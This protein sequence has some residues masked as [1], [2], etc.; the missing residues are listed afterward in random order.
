LKRLHIFYILILTF[1]P[2]QLLSQDE[3]SESI[4]FIEDLIEQI[5][6]ESDQELDYQTLLYDLSGY[7]EEPLNVNHASREELE[8]LH[9]LTDFQ[10]I[11][12]LQHIRDGG[13]LLTIYEL[14][15]VYGFDESL[16]R[17]L[18][19]LL[20][21]ESSA[22]SRELGEKTRPSHQLFLRF[23]SVIEEQKGFS[24][25][26]DSLLQANPNARYNGNRMKA[27]SKYRFRFGSRIEA[28][29]TGEKDAGEPFLQNENRHGF[30]FNSAYL[31]INDIG[32]FNTI[33]AGDYQARAGQ[34]V[35]LG[36]GL[37]F[38][39]SPDIINIRKKG[40]VLKPYSSSNENMFMRGLAASLEHKWLSMTGFISHKKIDANTYVDTIDNE[41]YFSSFLTSGLH[42]V[43]REFEDKDAVRETMLGGSATFHFGNLKT[44]ATVV[45]YFYDASYLKNDPVNMFHFSGMSNTNLG[46]DY[47]Y[48]GKKFIVFGEGGYSSNGTFAGLN[49]ASFDLHSQVTV[50]VL[51]RYFDRAFHALYGNA[52]TENSYNRN[53]H[54]L[55]TG[56]EI[57]PFPNWKISGYMDAYSFPYLKKLVT[58]PSTSGYDYHVQAEFSRRD[59]IHAYIRYKNKF[60][61]ENVS[62][63]QAGIPT[64]DRA[65]TSHL[66]FHISYPVAPGLTFADRV[67]ISAFE[68]ES[69]TQEGGFLAYHDVLYRP[70]S[71]PFSLTFRYSMFDT[72]S[73]K[74]RI[75]TYEHDV[76]YSF[77]IPNY[78]G[79][80]IRTYLTGRW[81][82]NR[83]VDLWLKYAMT[84]YPDRETI[85][86][87]LNEIEGHHRQDVRVQMRLKF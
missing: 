62:G 39:K 64:L 44:G 7:L 56:I 33:I 35:V 23:S 79:R 32:K 18:E 74:S 69:G 12:L 19:P 24:P 5:A 1:I 30:D 49:G 22:L 14:P 87:G 26:T 41:D 68:K 50:S 67:E 53:E 85:S 29:Y 65:R 25:A 63:D 45:H 16:A 76:L 10:I 11:S 3:A 37:S 15:M 80:G 9:V 42:S 71:L 86:S 46:I 73:Y 48:S 43:P 4:V 20:A 70:A 52:F 13:P 34:G 72:E 40:S 58:H 8:K 17:T 6:N 60:K 81:Q 27:L 31:R 59:G 82:I 2:A 66:R 36:S 21:F 51:H 57:L 84:W 55:Y 54:G 28:G 83:H 75:Y 38:G 78:F 47:M 61:S 77:S